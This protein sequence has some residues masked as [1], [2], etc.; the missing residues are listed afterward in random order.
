MTHI[1]IGICAYNEAGGIADMLR[2]CLRQTLF[3]DPAVTVR[4]VVLANGCKDDTAAVARAALAGS[5]IDFAVLDYAQGGKSRTLNRFV[6]EVSRAEADYLL[7]C[8][9]DIA[10]PDPTTFAR[11][12]ARIAGDARL[13]AVP[14]R[15][16]KDLSLRTT[17]L[18]ATEK[19]ILAGG[20]G[21][22]DWKHAICGQ[23]Y[24]ARASVMRAF[25][26]PIGLPVEDGFIRAMILTDNF[27]KDEDLTRIDGDDECYHVYESERTLGAVLTHQSRIVIGSAI[28]TLV[29]T[30]LR[31]EPAPARADL[32]RIAAQDENWLGTLIR[33]R[34]PKAPDGWV[35]VHFLVKRAAGFRDGGKASPGRLL[36]LGL[37]LGFDALVYA[38]AQLKMA[39]G[40]GA[41]HW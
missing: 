31:E 5:G 17:G 19:M 39:R 3:A 18:S 23:L 9:A 22:G 15:P 25:W 26:L 34:L 20:D 40:T 27:S 21:L 8:D 29:F 16:V 36:K 38:V 32:T 6:H 13:A 7:F 35:P 4:L 12:L 28:N 10:L 41:G 24:I 37:G 11:L 33:D 2:D 1:D 14:S 30:R